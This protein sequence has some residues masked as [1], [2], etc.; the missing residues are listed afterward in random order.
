MF[1][2]Q[3]LNVKTLIFKLSPIEKVLA[4]SNNDT[5]TKQRKDSFMINTNALKNYEQ[6]LEQKVI[7]NKFTGRG[8]YNSKMI[9]WLDEII[10]TSHYKAFKSIPFYELIKLFVKSKGGKMDYFFAAYYRSPKDDKTLNWSF[11]GYVINKIKGKIVYSENPDSLIKSYSDKNDLMAELEL[12]VQE[13]LVRKL[14][15]YFD[16]NKS[17]CLGKCISYIKSIVDSSVDGFFRDLQT[18]NRIM[19]NTITNGFFSFDESP[20]NKDLYHNSG[21][22]EKYILQN[23]TKPVIT[24]ALTGVTNYQQKVLE[25][26]YYE[27]LGPTEIGK[28]LGG[29]SRKAISDTRRR[30]LKGLNKFKEIKNL[31]IQ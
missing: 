31:R 1:A 13:D 9:E 30:A 26:S 17:D 27:N 14:I 16:I 3:L 2:L 22:E 15:K 8:F 20:N 19:K 12:H 25:L 4:I 24:K 7:G 29:R 5:N 21:I 28:K 23:V 6:M 11:K 18:R 10:D